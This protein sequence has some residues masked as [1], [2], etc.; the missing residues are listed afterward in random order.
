MVDIIPLSCAYILVGILF[1]V[2]LGI[3]IYEIW[4]LYTG[5]LKSNHYLHFDTEVHIA[6]LLTN[7]FKPQGVDRA[8]LCGGYEGCLW[9]RDI[10]LRYKEHVLVI[11]NIN[12]PKPLIY[13]LPFSNKKVNEWVLKL[14]EEEMFNHLKNDNDFELYMDDVKQFIRMVD[15]E[16]IK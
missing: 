5:I 16:H 3:V 9:S 4:Y 13:Y 6:N 11:P 15:N 10:R 8:L 12:F 14:T 2:P 1:G 7:I